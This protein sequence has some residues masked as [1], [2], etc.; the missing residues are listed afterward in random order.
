[1]LTFSLTIS[2]FAQD[3]KAKT[4]AFSKIAKLTQTKKPEDQEKAYVMAKEFL[5]KYGKDDDEQVKK[6]KDFVEKHRLAAFNKK[7]DEIKIAEAY[8]LG[9]EILA[10]EPENTYIVVNMAF[11]GYDA[12][13]KKKDDSFKADSVNYARQALGLLEAGKLP[14]TFEPFKDQAEATAIMHYII[15]TFTLDTDNTGAANNFYKALQYESQIKKTSYPYYAIAYTYEKAYEN[16]AKSYKAKVDSKAPD[17][18]IMAVQEKLE[19]IVERMLDAYARAIKYAETDKN[20]GRDAWKQRFTEIYKH[21]NQ[22]ETG[23]NEYLNSILDKP[24]PDPNTI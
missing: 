7:L 15:A 20:P 6:L 4:E 8:A 18:E 16:S 10:Q 14:A 12:F 2:A 3:N 11:G 24:F 21:K 22:S 23:L 13:D 5:V 19:K 17:A 1:M 9:K